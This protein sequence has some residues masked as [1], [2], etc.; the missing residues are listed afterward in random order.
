MSMTEL[1]KIIEDNGKG[2]R[3]YSECNRACRD[4]L[5]VQ[6]ETA[7]A[8]FLLSMVSEKFVDTY[9]DQPLSSSIAEA[10]FKRFKGY[11]GQ[12]EASERA[13]DP[14]E[15]LNTLNRI[16]DEIANHKLRLE[17]AKFQ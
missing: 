12:F 2:V 5:V 13:A 4:Q 6:S 9:D 10:E 3:A 16:A 15:K 7:A 1:V 8:Y 11:V 14:A 17:D